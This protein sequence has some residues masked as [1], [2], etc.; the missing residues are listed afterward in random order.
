MEKL[1]LMTAKLY[2]IRNTAKSFLMENYHEDLKPYMD[3]IKQVMEQRKID[4]LKAL[5][6]VSETKTYQDSGMAQ[7]LFV[8]AAVEIT[9]PSV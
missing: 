9:E 1:I 2:D 4:A 8:T 5:L 6:V 3:I 7:M